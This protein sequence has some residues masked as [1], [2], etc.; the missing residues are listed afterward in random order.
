MFVLVYEIRVFNKNNNIFDTTI[1]DLICLTMFLVLGEL[2]PIFVIFHQHYGS[3][4]VQ[5]DF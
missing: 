1:V 3:L 5:P 4:K 2:L